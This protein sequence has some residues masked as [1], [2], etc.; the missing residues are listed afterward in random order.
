MLYKQIVG[1]KKGQQIT[2][3]QDLR[4][5][6]LNDVRIKKIMEVGPDV[7]FQYGD[8]V[9]RLIQITAERPFGFIIVNEDKDFV[10]CFYM[11]TAESS[12]IG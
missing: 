8:P 9:Q 7:H 1:L 5:E 4:G 11:N 3:I 10:C 12:S 6:S 2:A